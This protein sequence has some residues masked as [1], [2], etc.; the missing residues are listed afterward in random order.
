MQLYNLIIV[1]S[2]FDLSLLERVT[3]E[4]ASS[5]VLPAGVPG[6]MPRYRLALALSFFYK[7]FLE[8]ARRENVSYYHLD[9]GTM[10]H[11]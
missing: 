5:L 6:G 7:H 9:T 8:V 2:R 10:S 4:L 1:F 11:E 3:C